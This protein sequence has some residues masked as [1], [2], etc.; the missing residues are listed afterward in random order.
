MKLTLFPALLNLF[1][2][3]CIVVAED[4][5]TT[6]PEL[7][8]SEATLSEALSGASIVVVAKVVRIGAAPSRKSGSYSAY[9]GVRLQVARILKGSIDSEVSVSLFVR[10]GDIMESVPQSD[11]TYVF[12]IN[13]AP[14]ALTVKKVLEANAESITKVTQS[15]S[16][17]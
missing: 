1:L 14:G 5:P 12:I 13:G 17:P 2:G 10:R 8:G 6:T 11:K 15:L 7:S 16:S 4:I 9:H 3:V